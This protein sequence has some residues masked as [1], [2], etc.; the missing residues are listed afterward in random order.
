MNREDHH[1]EDEGEESVEQSPFPNPRIYEGIWHASMP[2]GFDAVTIHL[3]GRMQS[4]L[5]WKNARK[6]AEEAVENGYG[7]MW[8]MEMGLFQELLH[9]LTSQSQFLSLTL[10]LEHFRDSLWKEFKF[11]TVGLILFRGSADFSIGFRWDEHQENNLRTWL[12]HLGESDLAALDLS[13]LQQHADGAQLMRLYCR[14]VAIEYLALLASRVPDSL[15]AY[16]FLDMQEVHRSLLAEIQL[17]NPERFD[18]LQ[19]AL[20]GHQLPFHALGWEKPTSVGYS[21]KLRASLSQEQIPS[22]GVCIPPMHFYQSKYYQGL[23]L[24]FLVL[25]Q[26][27]IPF[28]LIAE[29]HLTAEWDG[30][31][32]LLYVPEG[33]TPQGKRKLQ[34]FCAA[35]GTA[36]SVGQLMGLPQELS[37]DEWLLSL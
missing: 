36:V 27:G 2:T 24:A 35:G 23:E 22:V 29:S 32:Y 18:R 33:L 25:Q 11:R 31:D 16:L 14:D 1:H 19:L 26:Q 21:G 28:K 12:E 17:L 6:Q 8:E 3:N 37:F 4:D 5:D 9:P 30:L 34:G 10:S 20:R 15:P 13:L 7:V